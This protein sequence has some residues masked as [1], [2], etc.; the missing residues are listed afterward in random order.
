MK[1]SNKK[2][3]IGIILL[4]VTE[5]ILYAIYS[6]DTHEI[7]DSISFS[8]HNEDQIE[9]E[10]L[11]EIFNSTNKSVFKETYTLASGKEIDSPLLKKKDSRLEVTLDNDA[12]KKYVAILNSGE[13]NYIH[14]TGDPGEPIRVEIAYR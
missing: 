8:L 12:N 5:T 2:L 14:I 3:L 10:I 13:H 9:H 6:Y 11:I 1:S 7:G 4:I